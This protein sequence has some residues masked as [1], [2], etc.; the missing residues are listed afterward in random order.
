MFEAFQ[1]YSNFSRKA[2][3]SEFWGVTLTILVLSFVLGFVST[4]LMLA[5]GTLG[6]V[7]GL[8]LLIAGFIFLSWISIATIAA[9]CRDAG[10][11]PW[12]TLACFIPYIGTIVMIVIGC[13]GTKNE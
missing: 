7:F 13:L 4:G 1:K 2:K 10:I 12:F 3:R 8:P 5:G 11:N 9:R 6:F